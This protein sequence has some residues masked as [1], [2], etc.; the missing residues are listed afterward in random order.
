MFTLGVGEVLMGLFLKMDT[1]LEDN[2]FVLHLFLF[3]E[4]DLYIHICLI[5]FGEWVIF[6]VLIVI[7]GPKI[8]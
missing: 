6:Y 5:S 4:I 2:W 8:Y 3:D 7:T 1:L